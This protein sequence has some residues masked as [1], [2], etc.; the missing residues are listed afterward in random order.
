[1]LQTTDEQIILTLTNLARDGNDAGLSSYLESLNPEQKLLAAANNNRA[2][3]LAAINGHQ[4]AVQILLSI[5]T[6]FDNAAAGDNLA[7]LMA[8]RRK[9]P[10]VAQA[11]L[12]VQTVRDNAAV[13]NN[14]ALKCAAINDYGS[15]VR[16]LL[17]IS[18]V[19]HCTATDKENG[20]GHEAT[21]LS[22]AKAYNLLKGLLN[23]LNHFDNK[24]PKSKQNIKE[25]CSI[26]R[27][28]RDATPAA[29]SLHHSLIACA[30]NGG[31]IDI[32]N[33]LSPGYNYK[34]ILSSIP[35]KRLE[36][37]LTLKT[38]KAVRSY[39]E[40]DEQALLQAALKLGYPSVAKNLLT[41]L[42]EVSAN[43]A[44]FK[45]EA[46]RIAA[47]RGYSDIVGDLLSHPAVLNGASAY[48]KKII[49]L[50]FQAGRNSAQQGAQPDQECTVPAASQTLCWQFVGMKIEGGNAAAASEEKGD[51][52][53]PTQTKKQR[54]C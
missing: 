28:F 39:P 43:A 14:A 23:Y 46:L 53:H 20:H 21:L 22:T 45:N 41:D 4:R 6:V 38:I 40:T 33:D 2:L 8:L 32:V 7:L 12:T 3:Q 5:S 17:T 11:L 31:Y 9:H 1:M 50:T 24:T 26:L 29:E 10:L 54:H 49:N 30:T 18:T 48:I 42:P 36:K 27:A 37:V 13:Y 44:A 47:L 35:H 19:R 15:I 16:D 34:E 25:N 51:Y 52:V